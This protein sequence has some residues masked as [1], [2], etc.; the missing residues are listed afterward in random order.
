[1]LVWDVSSQQ[2]GGVPSEHSPAHTIGPYVV[3]AELGRGANGVV[4]LARRGPGADPCALKVFL[5]PEDT[6]G[7]ARFKIEVELASQLH[8]PGIVGA[9]ESGYHRRHPWVAMEYVAGETLRDRLRQGPLE[10]EEA[11][12]LLLTLAEAVGH[13][14]ARGVVHRD[15]KP[16][17]I[18][19][20][21][22]DHRPRITDFG[23]ACVRSDASSL[24]RTG[25]ALGTPHYMAPE[26]VLDSKRVDPRTDVYALGVILYES[27]SGRLPFGGA[28]VN[29]VFKEILQT[30]PPDLLPLAP[31][32][33]PGLV[34]VCQRAMAK[35]SEERFQSAED[36]IAALHAA[37][38]ARTR[39]RSWRTI[40]A[41]S[42][43]AGLI[44]GAVFWGLFGA[45]PDDRVTGA[46]DPQRDAEVPPV[47]AERPLSLEEKR[48]T[49]LARLQSRLAEIDFVTVTPREL[50][51]IT[52]GDFPELR[53][54]RDT[55]SRG[56]LGRVQ[57][58]ARLHAPFP[59]LMDLLEQAERLATA[60]SLKAQVQLDRATYA[61]RRGRFEEATRLASRIEEEGRIGLQARYV[62]AYGQL[63]QDRYPKGLGALEALW[64]DDPRGVV[65]MNAGA[66]FNSHTGRNGVGEELARAALAL[67]SDYVDAYI[68]LAFCLND[69]SHREPE[70]KDS[71][72]AE[73]LSSSAEAIRRCPDHPRAYMARAF[74]LGNSGRPQEALVAYDELI[75]LTQPRPMAR[76]LRQRA[77]YRIQLQRDHEGALADLE[78][79]LERDADD[80]EALTWRGVLRNQKGDA[81]AAAQDWVRA[82]KAN[83]KAMSRVLRGLP[84][85][86]RQH[87][88][89]V[90]RQRLR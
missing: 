79:A 36:L 17:N 7:L 34:E 25:T 4:Y 76:A 88:L 67:D 65:G 26:Q 48:A 74:A 12:S 30:R 27:L 50:A 86:L 28:T 56:L 3:E 80:A 14:H 75:R 89:S 37:P 68:S 63:W 52:L 38:S 55:L 45:P 73:S 32:A 21:K 10:A 62:A 44:T 78:S 85:D 47:S 84:Q 41:L 77:R 57:R 72:L 81:E 64:K 33:P 42:G 13:A 71:L 82:A 59:E 9:L 49:E 6:E 60:G 11:R 22:L 83:Q 29:E 87:I 53:S 8:H 43:V 18:I 16:E 54:A 46:P 40:L 2:N 1:V 20:N 69:L 90:V 39:G 35:R 15:I 23:L 66:V 24:T 31:E 61:F 5:N 58:R 70:R 51:S 19:L